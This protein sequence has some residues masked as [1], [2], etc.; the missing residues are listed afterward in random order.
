MSLKCTVRVNKGGLLEPFR[1]TQASPVLILR[2]DIYFLGEK[3]RKNILGTKH[4]MYKCREMVG[5]GRI[6]M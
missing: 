6:L 1:R 3:T 2:G 5:K 4:S